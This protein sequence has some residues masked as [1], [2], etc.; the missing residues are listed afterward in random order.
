MTQNRGRVWVIGLTGTIGAGKSTVARILREQ[1]VPVIDADQVAR[2]LSE[3]DGPVWAAISETFGPEVMNPDGSLNR[4]KLGAQ[5]FGN[6]DALKRLNAATHPPILDA[7]NE[8]VNTLSREGHSGPVVVEAPMLF[9]SS[10][11]RQVDEIWVVTAPEEKLIE[12]L[13]VRDGLDRREAEK[14]IQSQMPQAEKAKSA[15]QI[16]HNDGDKKV[17]KAQI[18]A[19]LA[20]RTTKGDIE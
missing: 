1:G 13:I 16:L 14:R 17:L 5:V 8:K 7:I 3:K 10:Y 2:E 12:R 11:D 20:E 4:K 15:H 18:E 9:E 19:L 6:P